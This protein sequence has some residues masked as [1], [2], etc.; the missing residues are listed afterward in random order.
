MKF[1]VT[2]LIGDPI[3]VTG[4]CD[5]RVAGKNLKS[6][7]LTNLSIIAGKSVLNH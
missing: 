1:S 5:G 3:L 7:L 2:P 6:I 4:G